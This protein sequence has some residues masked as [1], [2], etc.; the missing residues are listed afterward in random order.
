[1]KKIAGKNRGR[2]V[3]REPFGGVAIFLR[4]VQILWDVLGL[5]QDQFTTPEEYGKKMLQRLPKTP[6][7]D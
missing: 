1:L 2:G 6:K 4:L 3:V 5:R 7:R